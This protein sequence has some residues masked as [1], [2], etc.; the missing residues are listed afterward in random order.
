MLVSRDGP[1]DLRLASCVPVSSVL[2]PVFQSY[3]HVLPPQL[4]FLAQLFGPRMQN[5][6]H[7]YF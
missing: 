6:S 4:F 3:H 1:S 2:G 5:P 7:N